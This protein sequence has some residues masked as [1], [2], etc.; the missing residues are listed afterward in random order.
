[1]ANGK[2]TVGAERAAW[3][4]SVVEDVLWPN[5]RICDAHH[6]LWDH[7]G[8]RYFA[9]ELAADIGDGHNVRQTVYVECGSAYRTSGPAELAPVGETEFVVSQEAELAQLVGRPVITGIVGFADMLLGDAA[10]NVLEAH[11]EAGGGRF[12]G[13]RH[14]AAWDGS[15]D[16][17]NHQAGP[18]AQI[19]LD[20]RFA[21]GVAVLGKM[22]LTYDV[23][24]YH[25]QLPELV[26]LARKVPQTTIIADHLGGPIGLGPYAGKREE[27]LAYCREHLSEVAKLPNAR[28][29][30]GGIGMTVYGS[31]WHR[32]PKPPS[33]QVIAD[34]WGDQIRWCIDTFGP[35]RVMFESNFPPDGRSC[36]YRTLWNALK[37]TAERYSQAER[38]LLFHDS[39]V[40]IYNLK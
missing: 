3:R 21:K 37:Q 38:D 16:I 20:P 22:G 5:Q 32:L 13:I 15:P 25:K 12:C 4:A 40:A 35:E 17:V 26:E 27:V 2:S 31:G 9:A 11:V 39:A 6:H 18:P 29:K 24:L 28:V 23:W 8:D 30:L 33:S 19:L 10:Q 7:T 36:S 1:M 34:A 14:A